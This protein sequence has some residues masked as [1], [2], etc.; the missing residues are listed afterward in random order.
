[1]KQVLPLLLALVFSQSAYAIVNM[2]SLHTGTPKEGFSGKVELALS[3]TSGN[4]EKKD[5]A[6]G[7]RLQ[8]HKEKITDYLLLRG[9]YGES[10]G[11]KTT[12]KS[13]LHARH[14]YQY[15][16]RLAAEGYVQAEQDTF[17]RLEFRGLVGAGGRYTLYQRDD[18][19]VVYLGLGAYY[20]KERIDDNYPDGGT[21]KLWRGSTYL[22]L[23]YQATANTTLVSSSYY[24]PAFEGADDYRMLEQA[25][26][27]V[28]LNDMLS[29]VF[30]AD[31]SFDSQPPIGVE[32]RDITYTTSFSLEF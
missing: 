9:A 30:S 28:K 2:E 32:K 8:W 17:A 23:K 24:Q 7:S 5:Y 1:M 4:T 10:A 11:V 27:K 26:M 15:W 31:Y 16:P 22:I 14:I 29:L 25:T 6:L 21:D 20:S 19:G 18:H 13:F 12:E 3:S